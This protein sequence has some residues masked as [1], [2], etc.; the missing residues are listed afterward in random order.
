MCIVILF[1]LE[2]DKPTIV[3][4]SLTIESFG[5]IEEA[6]MVCICTNLSLSD[7]YLN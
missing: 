6:N 3:Q 2:N 1:S 5:N 7:S 4:C